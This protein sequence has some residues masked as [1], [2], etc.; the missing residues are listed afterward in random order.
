VIELDGNN[1]DAY[2]IAAEAMLAGGIDGGGPA[3]IAQGRKLIADAL[4]AGVAGPQLERAQALAAITMNQ[5]DR[6]LTKLVPMSAAAP[7]DGYLLVYQG[8]A[9]AAKGDGAAAIKAFD[10]ALTAAPALKQSVLY[11]RGKTKLAIG[12]IDGAHADFAAILEVDKDNIPAMIGIAAAS[13]PA[14]T[15]QREADLLAVLARKDIGSADPRS[16]VL[17]W[18][19]AA[20][21]ARQGGR[22]DV[23]RERYK[24]ALD[25]AP[26]D[27]AALTG[28]SAVELRD[29]KLELAGTLIQKAL[30]QSADDVDA[31]IVAA[32][33]AVRAG[34]LQDAG[35]ILGKLKDRTP[36]LL[37]LQQ[38]H[39]Q[40]V[41]GR[42]KEAQGDDD[43]AADA[44]TA[45][46]KAAG[47][48]DLTPTMAAVTKLGALTKK[49]VDA[50][51][52]AAA[53]GYR[54]RADELLSSLAARANDDAQL[55]MTLGVAYLEEGDAG[56][57]EGFLRRAVEMRGTDIEAKVALAK[58]LTKNGH[59]DD[60]LAQLGE[61]LALDKNRVD[62]ALE[63]AT[64]LE[65]AKRDGEAAAAYDKLLAA[66]DVPVPARVKAGKFFARIGDLKKAV[67]QADPILSA[68]PD[69]AAGHYLQG[70]KLLLAG[71]L[72]DARKE[73][74]LAVDADPDVR[75]LDAQGRAAEASD[76]ATG[77]TKFQDLAL[78]AY[79]RATEVDPTL[80]NPWAGMG[81]LFVKRKEFEK[82]VAPLTQANKLAP[83]DADV[84]FDFGRTAAALQQ[85]PQAITWLQQS[86]K[87][88]PRGEA[89]YLLGHLD[90]DVNRAN[91]M[92][93][94]FTQ[95]TQLGT[96]EEKQHAVAWLT[97]AWFQLGRAHIY[98][99]DECGAKRPYQTYLSRNPPDSSSRREA[100]EFLGTTGR[101][102]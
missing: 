1:V 83:S 41:L 25:V 48:L 46:A 5:G 99:H 82:A 33:L 101:G 10:A 78:H 76:S 77:D 62:I 19:L 87:L 65:A 51:D 4:A 52:N 3:K 22:L 43:A 21:V 20:D 96:E 75:Y 17:A 85:K 54:K 70:E 66:A 88:K 89:Y 7:K 37:P 63:I 38:A 40:V 93:A 57:A 72:D 13:P 100:S 34:K 29:N 67:S 58:A 30:T 31:Q 2:G 9:Q 36:P 69:N 73:L 6:A 90:E 92:L 86:V 49:A 35:G 11:A 24:K 50:K 74:Q 26:T 12:D 28:L 91:E 95:A 53:D 45:G 81:R 97:D 59:P 16:I 8:W 98:L 61:A 32:E 94:H 42:L 80:F 84:M 39:A 15:S 47:E 71:K 68:D 27:V 60:G 79:T 14:Q 55:S 64:T 23:A 56:K 44:Y 102:C 18:T